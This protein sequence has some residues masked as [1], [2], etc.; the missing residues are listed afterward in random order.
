MTI[1]IHGMKKGRLLEINA[2]QYRNHT[3]QLHNVNQVK[4]QLKSNKYFDAGHSINLLNKVDGSETVIANDVSLQEKIES[5][6]FRV[7]NDP[8]LQESFE[9]LDNKLLKNKDLQNFRDYITQNQYLLRE[10][11]DLAAFEKKLWLQ[12]IF[13]A[14]DEYNLLIDEYEKGQV[15]LQT[16]VSE[17]Q[18]DRNAWNDVIDDFNDRFLHLPFQLDVENKS[19]VI[20]KDIA[21][22]I[23]FNFSDGEETR[24]YQERNE[25]LSVL[26]AGEARALYILNIMFEVHTR[27]QVRKKTLF[28]FD[29][30]ADSF[31]YKNKFA[32]ID[33]LDYLIKPEDTNFLAIVLTH[34]FDFLRTIESRGIC[35]S[36]QCYLA[37]KDQGQITLTLFE[38]RSD[39]R[40]PFQKWQNRLGEP[41]IQIAYIPFLRNLIEY[42]Q[43]SKNE[44]GEDNPDY[45]TLTE[46]LHYKDGSDNLLVKDYKDI[47]ERHF[48]KPSFPDIDLNQGV[49]S[50]IIQTADGCQNKDSGINL[51]HKIVLSI[52]TRILAEKFIVMKIQK[53][54]PDYETTNKQMGKLLQDFR[55][56]YNNLLEEIRLLKRVNLMTPANIHLNAFMYEPILDM[57][58]DELKELFQRVK[59]K[60]D[61]SL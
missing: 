30:I 53:D 25:I 2:T 22:S 49:L 29:D 50:Y 12:Y 51:E 48:A 7:L 54:E 8:A 43:G 32:I 1:G 5:E 27:W 15:E 13:K 10:L 23:V 26:S 17:A 39:I 55:D 21:P 9:T 28:I 42:T 57:G 11:K 58:F 45:K 52:A 14:N 24:Q 3:L 60:I 40:N 33:Y 61:S 59:L 4:Q 6:K 31:D 20:L 34:N 35:P 47:F 18:K 41:E 37:Q 36:F 19:D 38:N 16:I 46:M 56:R 44:I